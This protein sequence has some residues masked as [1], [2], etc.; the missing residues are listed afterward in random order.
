MSSGKINFQ[1]VLV[2]KEVNTAESAKKLPPKP[3]MK[4]ECRGMTWQ[5]RLVYAT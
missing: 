2:L 5:F 1:V 4:M 3:R